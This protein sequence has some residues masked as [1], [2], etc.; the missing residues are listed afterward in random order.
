MLPAHPSA[1]NTVSF[2][3]KNYHKSSKLCAWVLNH[4]KRREQKRIFHSCHFLRL[5]LIMSLIPAHHSQS[6]SF[7]ISW[8]IL[9][10]LWRG[11]IDVWTNSHHSL[12]LFQNGKWFMQS[13]SGFPLI[14]ASIEELYYLL[15]ACPYSRHH[16]CHC[17]YC[18]QNRTS[19]FTSALAPPE[20]LIYYSCPA[21]TDQFRLYYH[22]TDL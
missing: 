19:F 10:L 2:R 7:R 14:L 17:R 22:S 9:S 5:V 20:H 3:V 1:G 6:Q 11:I 15:C 21:N 4:P 18:S 12:E 13:C 8:S 16:H